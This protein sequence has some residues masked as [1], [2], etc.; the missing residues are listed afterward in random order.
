MRDRATGRRRTN[1]WL[2]Q[3]GLLILTL[4]SM[5]GSSPTPASAAPRPVRVIKDVIYE[6]VDGVGLP[7]TVFVP[8][9]RGPFPGVLFIHGGKFDTGD[10]CQLGT[11]A[12]VSHLASLGLVVYSIDYRLAPKIDAEPTKLHCANGSTMD[13]AKFQGHHFPAAPQ[14]AAAALRWVR[15][16]ATRFKTDPSRIS[17]VG[18]SAGGTLCYGLGARGLVDAQVGW[19]GPTKLDIPFARRVTTNYIGCA[20]PEPVTLR[21]SGVL[22]PIALLVAFDLILGVVWLLRRRRR[23]NR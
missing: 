7:L 3:A 10:K 16:H 22:L 19:S 23:A 9:G 5:V 8:P 18:S 20:L 6:R 13:V 12:S 14:D 11:V 2:V 15:A 1:R 4:V 17:C 21:S